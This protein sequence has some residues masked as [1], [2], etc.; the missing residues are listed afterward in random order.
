ML[1]NIY[2]NLLPYSN[3]TSFRSEV[4]FVDSLIIMCFSRLDPRVSM[5]TRLKHRV[6]HVLLN[7]NLPWSNTTHSLNS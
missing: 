4:I 5:E 1:L 2:I 3:A 6:S 7:L